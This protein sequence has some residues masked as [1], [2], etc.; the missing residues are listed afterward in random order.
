MQSHFVNTNHIKLHYLDS[1]GN[2]P[3]LLLTHGLTANCHAFDGLIR[4]GLTDYVRLISPDLRG[5]GQSDQ[6]AEG[7]SMKE[8]AADILG[9]MDDLGIEKCHFGGHSFGGLLGIYMAVKHPERVDKLV[10]LDAGSE[11]HEK[12]REMLG[13][14]MGRLGQVYESQEYYIN[15]VKNAPYLPFWDEA[16]ESYYQAD[17]RV[18][19]DGK[20]I[21]IPTVDGIAK[22]ITQG[23]FGEP[24]PEYI[25]KIEHETILINGTGNYVIDAPLLPVENAKATAAAMKHCQYVAV[26][27]NHQ[28]MLYGQGAKQMVEALGEFLG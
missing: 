28:T 10:L 3:V 15:K 5:R 19:D 11:F 16:M 18:L 9:L 23:S 13:P 7:Y 14:T 1:G 20:V 6:P 22:A 17:I 4:A 27:G 8:H 2:K 26:D 24:W 21:P 12:V 25:P